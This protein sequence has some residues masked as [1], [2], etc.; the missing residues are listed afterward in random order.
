VPLV[1]RRDHR[2]AKAINAFSNPTTNSYKRLVPG[3][4][5]P[6]KLAY[7]ARNRSASV[8]IPYVTSPKAKRIEVRFPDAMGAP[9]LTYTALLMAGLDG[10]ENRIDPGP[11]LDKNLYDLPPRERTKV[12]EVAARCVRRWPRSTRTAPFSRRAASWTTTSSTPSSR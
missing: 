8:R 5:A 11:A 4:E 3:Y 2:H 1:H 7:S 10:I 6:V 9:H 12:P